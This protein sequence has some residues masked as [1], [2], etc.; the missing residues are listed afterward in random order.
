MGGRLS[1]LRSCYILVLVSLASALQSTVVP[2]NKCCAVCGN[3]T[4]KYWNR[5]L[6]QGTCGE[7][8]MDPKDYW[9]YKI[10]GLKTTESVTPCADADYPLYNETTTHGFG[11]VKFTMDLYR[12]LKEPMMAGMPMECTD[13]FS[14]ATCTS[15]K[16]KGKK[17]K[18]SWCT[19]KDGVHSLCFDKQSA[20][21]LDDTW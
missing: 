1:M 11:P 4:Q 14:K 3:G 9:K 7:L 16:R 18:C 6:L 15:K 8:C 17:T 12:K 10:F 2:D 21:H 19:T 13:A 20:S 5:D